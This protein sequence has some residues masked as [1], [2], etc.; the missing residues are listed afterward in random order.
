[1]NPARS[2][3]PALLSGNWT[4]WWVYLVG[5]VAGVLLA[6]VVDKGLQLREAPKEL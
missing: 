3:A 4:A 6:V 5:P 2:L 1:M